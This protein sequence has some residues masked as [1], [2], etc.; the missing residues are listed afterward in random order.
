MRWGLAAM[1]ATLL[2]LGAVLL[3]RWRKRP[4][5]GPPPT[6]CPRVEPRVGDPCGRPGLLC[7]YDRSGWEPGCSSLV[8]CDNKRTWTEHADPDEESCK[9]RNA[10]LGASCPSGYGSAPRGSAC[11]SRVTC[12]YPEGRCACT[13][14]CVDEHA[15]KQP[16]SGVWKCD[17]APD[18]CPHPRPTL[19]SPCA[20]PGLR[21]SYEVCC[22]GAEV[23]CRDGA[24]WALLV[25]LGCEDDEK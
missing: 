4:P 10:G 25:N 14:A 6:S 7:E 19:G 17:D 3:L 5:P 9:L 15:A 8:Q 22:T 24:W 11:T 21:C 16:A 1:V 20:T 2:S 13:V 18:G 12:D 23:E